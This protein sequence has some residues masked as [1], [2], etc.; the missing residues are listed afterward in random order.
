MEY[1]LVE[2]VIADRHG[3]EN[4]SYYTEY[5]SSWPR[6]WQKVNGSETSSFKVS[7][8]LYLDLVAPPTV[9]TEV[10]ATNEVK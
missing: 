8:N 1:R 4:K 5:S 10:L 7:E 9:T 2:K 3:A 6:Q